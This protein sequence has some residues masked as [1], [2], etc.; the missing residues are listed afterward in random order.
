MKESEDRYDIKQSLF[1][2]T[3]QSKNSTEALKLK[4]AKGMK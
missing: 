4:Q 3:L 2:S 1:R